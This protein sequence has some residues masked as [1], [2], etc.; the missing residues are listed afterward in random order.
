MADIYKIATLIVNGMSSSMRMKMLEN[1][2]HKQE[3]DILLLQEVARHDFDIR[4]YNAYTNVGTQRRGTAM[5]TREQIFLTNIT[6]LPSGRGMAASCRG[7][8]LLNI[9]APSGSANRLERESFYNIE[10]TYLLRSLPP[11]MIIGGDFN[12]VLSKTGCTGIINYSKALDNVPRE[13]GLIDV[14]GTVPQGTCK[15]YTPNG[16]ARLGRF[17]HT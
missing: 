3:I 16:A 17:C 6:R 14:W 11:T 2:L 5:L 13:F 10:L 15:H 7:V 1:F 9:Y 4:G 12:C 8:W